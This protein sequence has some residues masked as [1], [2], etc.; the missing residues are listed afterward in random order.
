MKDLAGAIISIAEKKIKGVFH[1]SG[2]DVLTPYQMAYKVA[3]YLG[4]P[5]E[6]LKKAS[7][8]DFSQPAKRPLKTGFNIEKAKRELNF[9]PTSFEEGLRKTFA[10]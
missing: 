2:N 1:I 4:L 10:E 6:L 9:Q 8:A 7:A 3:A 5:K